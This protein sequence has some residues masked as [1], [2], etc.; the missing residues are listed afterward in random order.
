MVPLRGD[1]RRRP[2]QRRPPAEPA[3]AANPRPRA[4]PPRRVVP[5]EVQAI[6]DAFDRGNY[7]A[8]EKA[9]SQPN[10]LANLIRAFRSDS[11]WPND[12]KRTAVFALE[13][14]FAGLRS[15]NATRVKKAGGCSPN[16]TL[17]CASRTAP[18]RSS[19]RGS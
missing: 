11:P 5:A 13:M 18:T 6:A 4:P 7:A 16:I 19:A 12:P 3:P 15:D 9:L 2:Q 14:A 8:V 1:P 17:A 10:S